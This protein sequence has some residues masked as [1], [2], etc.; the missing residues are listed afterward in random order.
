M[1]LKGF[2]TKTQWNLKTDHDM[3]KWDKGYKD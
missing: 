3:G 2:K 1:V